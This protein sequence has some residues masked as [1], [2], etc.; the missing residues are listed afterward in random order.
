MK[1]T[2][3]A[4]IG[5]TLLAACRLEPLDTDAVRPMSCAEIA[6]SVKIVFEDADVLVVNKPSGVPVFAAKDGREN[7]NVLLRRKAVC[8]NAAAE[9]AFPVVDIDSDA[10]GLVLFAKNEFQRDFLR[11][12]AANGG[13]EMKFRAVAERTFPVEN[14]VIDR[15]LTVGEDGKTRPAPFGQGVKAE[16]EYRVVK[17]PGRSSYVDIYPKTVFPHQIRAH[18]AYIKHPLFADALYG[19]TYSREFQNN[20]LLQAYYLRFKKGDSKEVLEIELSP[21]EQIMRAFDFAER[22]QAENAG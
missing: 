17:R 10:H 9:K 14:G 8:E 6:K 16:T 3:L 11:E 1:K 20:A 19:A 5:L 21:S 7:L 13:I 15:S 18:F 22:E 12:Q 2:W 4:T